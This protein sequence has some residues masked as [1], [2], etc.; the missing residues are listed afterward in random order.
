MPKDMH[1]AHPAL[2]RR[3]GGQ[4]VFADAPPLALTDRG[5]GWIDLAAP[6]GPGALDRAFA[7][8]EALSN[9]GPETAIRLA[10]P[11]WEP[12][13]PRLFE[14]GAAFRVDGAPTVLPA[15]FWQAPAR[16]LPRAP[17]PFPTIWRAGPRGRFPQRPPKP[18]GEVYRRHIPW[19]D[20][21]F[22][23]RAVSMDDLPT[24]HRWQNDPR[25]AAFF[26]EAGDL[27][28]HRAYL[29]RLFDDPHMLPLIGA[30]DGRDFVYFELYWARENRIGAHYDA[31]AWDR[32]W[33]VLVGESDLRGADYVTAWMPSL[34]HYMFLAEPRT[35]AVMG[36]PKAS[37]LRQ[38]ANLGQCGF[39]HL[40]DFDFPHKRAALVR[41][42]RQ[43]FF[44]A[45]LWARPES[46]RG[47]PLD[48]APAR[49]LTLGEPR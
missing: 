12:L 34:M 4:L 38:L 24:F 18:A 30:I 22:T 3:D 49:L 9:H 29:R 42:E 46:G 47:A 41:L 8:F 43:H 2:A 44:E 10:G 32:G 33:H 23:L 45:P 6:E 7:A 40:R 5:G 27:D 39:G 25:V 31:G 15:A 1:Q 20:Q 13:L 37:H 28:A 11:T 36:E 26:E 35:E 16:W 19:L 14:T 21:W 48:L 17:A